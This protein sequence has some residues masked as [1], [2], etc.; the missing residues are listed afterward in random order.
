[1][2]K[3]LEEQVEEV[4]KELPFGSSTESG[5]FFDNLDDT[6][7]INMNT[8]LDDIEI[9]SIMVIDSL[10]DL[11]IFGEEATAMTRRKKE[12]AISRGGKGREEK[13]QAFQAIVKT[14]GGMGIGE[15]FKDLFRR[16][17]DESIK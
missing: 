16:R 15:S 9:G 13:V 4:G 5:E 3:K 6:E 12:L 10:R 2:T 7:K 8:R 14:R 11:G 1:M 17:E